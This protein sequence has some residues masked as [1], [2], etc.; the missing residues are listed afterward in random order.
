GRRQTRQARPS[1]GRILGFRTGD[2]GDQ[3]DRDSE[4]DPAGWRGRRARRGALAVAEARAGRKA[5]R[6][7]DGLGAAHAPRAV[8]AALARG[9]SGLVSPAPAPPLPPS[10]A[11]DTES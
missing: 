10:L 3:V 9:A 8:A 1:R 2:R 4:T 5:G 6:R 7:A 11:A